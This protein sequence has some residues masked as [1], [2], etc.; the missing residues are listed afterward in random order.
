[1]LTQRLEALQ[2]SSGSEAAP[3]W[4]ASGRGSISAPGSRAHTRQASIASASALSLD[5][6]SLD[7][8]RMARVPLSIGTAAPPYRAAPGELSVSSCLSMFCAEERLEGV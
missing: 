3:E 6:V 5:A 1:M 7:D 2:T 4:K 8:E